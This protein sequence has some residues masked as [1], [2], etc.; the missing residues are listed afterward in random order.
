MNHNKHGDLMNGDDF[1]D[2]NNSSS[3]NS[4]SLTKLEPINN[5]LGG[6]SYLMDSSKDMSTS[7]STAM[8]IPCTRNTM[9][10]FT[11]FFD[12]DQSLSP[13]SIQEQDLLSSYGMQP[14]TSNNS[15]TMWGAI[16]DAIGMQHKVE[17]FSM[18]EE[19]I[20]QVDKA[21]LFQSP[22]LAELND[23][24][25][26]EDLNIDEFILQED[27]AT[28]MLSS[29]HPT[30][31]LLQPSQNGIGTSNLLPQH[32]LQQQQQ[33]HQLQQQHLQQH[34]QQQQQ[35]LQSNQM[36]GIN[37]GQ[38][39]MYDEQTNSSSPLHRYQTTPTKSVHSRDA[40]SPQSQTSS[41][42]SYLVNSVSPPSQGRSQQPR[43]STLQQLLKKEYNAMSPERTQLGQ[44]VPGPSTSMLMAA[45]SDQHNNDTAY[46]NRRLQQFSQQQSSAASR[47]SSS[48]PTH[49]SGLWDA[50]QMMWA[51]REPRQHLISTGSM[52]EA[53]STSSLSTGGI[54]SPEAPDFSHDEGYDDSDS[55]HYEDYSTDN[56]KFAI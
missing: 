21:D 1:Y 39:T 50:H 53:E 55:D 20:F 6:G 22:T 43:Y 29:P 3:T 52:A 46:T 13:Q 38:E 12:I 27:N 35:H 26:L 2:D 17:S 32:L 24:T 25:I 14:T 37:I 33:Q 36:L 5:N 44:S 51:R 56:G 18:D 16:G 31:I 42:S 9:S 47:L 40:L 8:P 7:S 48:A 45:A 30:L 4:F 23:D 19:D 10:D 28:L 41:N 49:S 34:L 11:G 15:N 54:L